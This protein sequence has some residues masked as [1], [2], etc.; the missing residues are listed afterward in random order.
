M[1]THPSIR[2]AAA[3]FAEELKPVQHRCPAPATFPSASSAAVF[4]WRRPRRSM[5]WNGLRA[6]GVRFLSHRV[7]H[8]RE[9]E[10]HGLCAV[11]HGSVF[12]TAND[13]V[14]A[15]VQ[16]TQRKSTPSS[17]RQILTL[18]EKNLAPFH[19]YSACI[20]E[21]IRKYRGVEERVR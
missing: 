7:G 16:G 15:R 13:A 1:P 10:Q 17:L 6:R 8:D 12:V 19:S 20:V 2:L 18:S 5:Q 9:H 21:T 11:C 4:H 3:L 14:V